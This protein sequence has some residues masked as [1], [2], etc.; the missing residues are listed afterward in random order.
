[1]LKKQTKRQCVSRERIVYRFHIWNQNI[2]DDRSK[3]TDQRTRGRTDVD[4]RTVCST[5]S[6]R[7]GN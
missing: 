7:F 1:M 5:A 2:D 3:L 6:A 4:Q